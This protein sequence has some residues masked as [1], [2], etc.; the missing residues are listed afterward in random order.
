MANLST[1][2]KKILNEL[3]NEIEVIK[4]LY[5]ASSDSINDVIHEQINTTVVDKYENDC[6]KCFLLY[7]RNTNHN[8]QNIINSVEELKE[9]FTGKKL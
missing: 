8:I 3:F 7:A 1:L 9:H 2:E 6:M 5:E 4:V